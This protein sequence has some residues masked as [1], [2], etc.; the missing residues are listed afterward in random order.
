[1]NVLFMG[2]PRF[3]VAALEAL[4]E[5]GHAVTGVVTRPDKPAGR[6][7]KP[8]ASPVKE[9][10]GRLGLPLS[11]PPRINAPETVDALR[12]LEPDV[13]VVTAF[14]A[15]LR[16][17][18][19]ELAPHGAVNVHASLLPDYRGVAPVQW[20]LI[21]GAAETG[22]TTMLMDEGVDTG[23]ILEQQTMA[24]ARGETAGTVLERLGRAGGTLLVHTLAGLADGSLVP[25]PQPD[26]G[27]YAPRL[28]RVH[29]HLNL[30]RVRD[31]VVDQFRGTTP[32]PGARVFL[33]ADAVLVTALEPAPEGEGAPYTILDAGRGRVRVACGGGA[34]D[35]LEVRPP[36]RNTMSADAFARGRGLVPG[37]RFDAPGE[38]PELDLRQTA[39]R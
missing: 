9:A 17:P 31:R 1:M 11:Q 28:E 20:A 29:G 37:R 15:I 21:H 18:L 14:G 25:R 5:A 10:A 34:V 6:G 2:T 16:R 4:V 36:G 3:A 30:A 26:S 38:L 8:V 39:V 35:L 32:V 19:L 13:V 33:G 7:R 22:V 24:V 23:P 12:A 27:T